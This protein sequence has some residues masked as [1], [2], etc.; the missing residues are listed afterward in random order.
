MHALT[1]LLA[2]VCV[3]GRPCAAHIPF[4]AN[5]NVCLHHLAVAIFSFLSVYI[6]L[7]ARTANG[8]PVR[9]QEVC[10][11][12]KHVAHPAHILRTSICAMLQVPLQRLGCCELLPILLK[13]HTL[14]W[15]SGKVA[16]L[17]TEV[18][19]DQKVPLACNA[20]ARHVRQN[21]PSSATCP[22]WL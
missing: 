10:S 9:T 20:H 13:L 18:L 4:L 1:N 7:S 19:C 14:W 5:V 16:P 8:Q 12:R 2:C 15:C 22:S 6:I 17:L 21:C 11:C 3:H